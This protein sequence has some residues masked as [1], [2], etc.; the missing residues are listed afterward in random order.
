MG[1]A[2]LV[3]LGDIDSGNWA[4]D[5]AEVSGT[6]IGLNLIFSYSNY[7]WCTNYRF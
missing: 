3:S 5:I 1:P 6:T 7:I 4:T 2:Y